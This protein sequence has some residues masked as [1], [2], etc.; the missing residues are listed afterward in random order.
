MKCIK[1]NLIKSFLG[2]GGLSRFCL[3]CLGSFMFLLPNSFFG[4]HYER[5][6]CWLFQKRS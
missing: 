1:T 3:Y 6:R 2:I 4:F 5:I